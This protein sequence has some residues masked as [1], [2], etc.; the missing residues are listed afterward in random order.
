MSRLIRIELGR[1]SVFY[2]PTLVAVHGGFLE[3]EGLDPV[4]TRPAA[5]KSSVDSLLDG[6]VH[7]A[8]SAPSRS[9]PYV[10]QGGRAPFVHFASVNERDG[11][12][13][14]AREPDPDFAWLKV[15]SATI[16]V[17]QTHQPRVMLSRAVE[18]HGG[19]VTHMKLLEIDSDQEQAF[20]NGRGDYL[21]VQGPAAQQ[22]EADG[23]GHIVASV[24][25]AVGDLAFT[26]LAATRGWLETD[27]AHRFSRAYAKA[28]AWLSQAPIYD[29]AAIVALAMPHVRPAVLNAAIATYRRLGTWPISGQISKA[30]FERM[31]DAF[32]AVG[33]VVQRPAYE[34]VVTSFSLDRG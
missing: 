9:L 14:V 29:I 33:E 25:Q 13:L 16:I 32:V 27:D 26:S 21:H 11:F 22:L 3:R 4:Q 10:L 17:G 5:G 24:G 8:Q 18:L 31:L 1:I 6:S 34:D 19:S 20:L 12:F 7:V 2:A 15:K 23:V 28:L 30:S